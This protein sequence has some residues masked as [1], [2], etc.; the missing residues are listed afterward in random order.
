V[1]QSIAYAVK[2][3][4]QQLFCLLLSVISLQSLH[5]GFSDSFTAS[6]DK[7]IVLPSYELQ[8]VLL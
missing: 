5:N 1:P 8:Q 7:T 3:I 4:D 6:T 2:R